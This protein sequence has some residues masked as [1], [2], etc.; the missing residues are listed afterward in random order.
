M[1]R[2]KTFHRQVSVK[3]D[4]FL[5]IVGVLVVYTHSSLAL[6]V[7]LYDNKTVAMCTYPLASIEALYMGSFPYTLIDF[8]YITL[9]IVD[10]P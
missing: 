6:F 2:N 3:S 5:S 9:E 10:I 1:V 4:P 7:V 8:M